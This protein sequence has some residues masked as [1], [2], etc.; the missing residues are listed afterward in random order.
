MTNIYQTINP[1]NKDIHSDI[2]FQ[3]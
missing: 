2:I 1:H 3:I